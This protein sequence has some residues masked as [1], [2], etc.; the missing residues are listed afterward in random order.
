MWGIM[1][2]VARVLAASACLVTLAACDITSRN[3][4]LTPGQDA[5]VDATVTGTTV[6]PSAPNPDVADTLQGGDPYDDLNTGKKLWRGCH[7]RRRGTQIL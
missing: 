6:A 5:P 3:A 1:R 4:S 2:I 7:P